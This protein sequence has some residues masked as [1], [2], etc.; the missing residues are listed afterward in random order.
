MA[1]YRHGHQFW[2][3]RQCPRSGRADPRVPPR[4]QGALARHEDPTQASRPFDTARNGIVASEG[5]CLYVVE[6]LPDALRR[7]ARIVAELV[8]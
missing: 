6:R 7:G 8:L 5:G 2:R 4:D 3:H 1:R